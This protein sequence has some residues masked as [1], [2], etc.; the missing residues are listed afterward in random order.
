MADPCW[1]VKREDGQYL[2]GSHGFLEGRPNAYRFRETLGRDTPRQW[3]QSCADA[4]NRQSGVLRARVVKLVPKARKPWK[5]P[6]TR[7]QIGDVVRSHPDYPA[8][9]FSAE[10]GTVDDVI[11]EWVHG[12]WRE[13]ITFKTKSSV[14]AGNADLFALVERPAQP[15]SQPQEKK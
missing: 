12:E 14:G 1:I 9:P 7:F 11:Q 10:H 15:S 3:A 5:P 8:G 6:T 4:W 2:S 13:Y